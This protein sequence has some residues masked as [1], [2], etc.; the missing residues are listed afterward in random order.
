[1]YRF[2][3]V[4]ASYLNNDSVKFIV[5]YKLIIIMKNMQTLNFHIISIVQ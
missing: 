5:V 3:C 4:F 2:D 1:M